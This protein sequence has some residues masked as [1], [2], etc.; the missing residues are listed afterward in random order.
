AA[1]THSPGGFVK[2]GVRLEKY[3]NRR[4]QD[5]VILV[6]AKVAELGSARQA[7][8]WFLEYGL[9]LPAKRNNVTWSGVGQICDH[10]SDDL[11]RRLRLLVRVV[12]RQDMMQRQ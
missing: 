12:S 6:L 2:V 5:T 3:P 8:L 11:R 9:D 7:L 1:L 4:V 10:P